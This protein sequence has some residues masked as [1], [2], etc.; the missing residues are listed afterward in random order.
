MISN[1]LKCGFIRPRHAFPLRSSPPQ[2]SRA[3]E[4]LDV[5]DECL[6]HLCLPTMVSQRFHVVMSFTQSFNAVT[7]GGLDSLN[8]LIIL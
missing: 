6:S 2:M 8:L 5:P 4:K 1:N 7:P 3:L